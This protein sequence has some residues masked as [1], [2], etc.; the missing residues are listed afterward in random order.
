MGKERLT[1]EIDSELME[2]LRA[3]GVDPQ[4][5]LE[6]LLARQAA[7]QETAEQRAAREGALRA[8][9]Q[10]GLDDYDAFIAKYGLWSDNLRQF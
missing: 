1:I 2:R 4:A 3:A 8:E 5:Y 9:M 10:Q 7:N 6:R